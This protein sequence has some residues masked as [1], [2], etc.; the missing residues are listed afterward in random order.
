[1]N[2]FVLGPNSVG[3]ASIHRNEAFRTQWRTP[4]VVHL[5]P[6]VSPAGF[7][8]GRVRGITMPGAVVEIYWDQRA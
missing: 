5:T 2:S 8:G 1:M 3:F 7:R 4:N 6:D